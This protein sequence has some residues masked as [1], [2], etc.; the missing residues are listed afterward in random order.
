M[1]LPPLIREHL[2]WDEFAKL[3]ARGVKEVMGSLY[4][5]DLFR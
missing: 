5:P 2:R 4:D 3:K 1:S